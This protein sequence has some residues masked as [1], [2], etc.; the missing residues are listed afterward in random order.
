[1]NAG[2]KGAEAGILVGENILEIN[3]QST[4][5]LFHVAA[6]KLI[7]N[8]GFNLILT[9]DR[10]TGK[11]GIAP[12]KDQP[13]PAK[14]PLVT[15]SQFQPLVKPVSKG[16]YQPLPTALSKPV[17]STPVEPVPV[18]KAVK[19]VSAPVPPPVFPDFPAPPPEL[20]TP[21]KSKPA[22]SSTGAGTPD[23]LDRPS[24]LAPRNE[25]QKSTQNYS[26][27]SPI[28][29]KSNPVSA[30]F[31]KTVTLPVSAPVSNLP[32][33]APSKTA[34][35]FQQP[36]PPT[37]METFKLNI[38]S[39]ELENQLDDMKLANDPAGREGFNFNLYAKIIIYKY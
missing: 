17:S 1:M 14:V 39:N 19:P 2:G 37:Q 9:L 29:P 35:P 6:Q 12:V 33:K 3:G 24:V 21:V 5:G 38:D 22:G 8:T 4:Q 36:Q 10:S 32:P 27:I 28:I 16:N 30:P 18:S 15:K 20:T 31:T 13:P 25:I 34:Q 23:I 11:P 26:N 7:K